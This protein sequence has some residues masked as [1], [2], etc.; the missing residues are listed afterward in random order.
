VTTPAGEDNVIY[1]EGKAAVDT[2]MFAI[3]LQYGADGE[4]SSQQNSLCV[5]VKPDGNNAFA[6]RINTAPGNKDIPTA[7]VG[8][9]MPAQGNW[10]TMPGW[11]EVPVMEEGLHRLVITSAYTDEDAYI[12][13]NAYGGTLGD[14]T[15]YKG[16]ANGSLSGRNGLTTWKGAV[17]QVAGSSNNPKLVDFPN[18]RNARIAL[19]S[20]LEPSP[21][22]IDAYPGAYIR[23][24]D[25]YLTDLMGIL[26]N[27]NG[28]TDQPSTPLTDSQVA[29]FAKV[30]DA[31]TA[32]CND[33]YQKLR[34]IYEYISS[35]FYYD[36]YDHATEGH[37][38]CNP[39]YNLYAL[40]NK[41]KMPNGD[42]VSNGDGTGKVATVCD[43]YA[44]MIIAL[45]RAEG[46][47][48]RI[49]KGF[50]IEG[51]NPHATW[52][53]TTVEGSN[54]LWAEAY[55]DGRWMMLDAKRGTYNRWDR[56][57]GSDPGTWTK[58]DYISYAAFDMSDECFNASYVVTEMRGGDVDGKYLANKGEYEQL[59]AFLNA[60][61]NGKKLNSAYTP[62]DP[63]TWG[64][65][66]DPD[67]GKFL[68]AGTDGYGR[69]F[70]ISW[71]GKGLAGELDLSNFT[72]L[73]YLTINTND[74]T[75]LKVDGCTALAKLYAGYNDLTSFDSTGCP[76][77]EHIALKDN[78]LTQA[79]FLHKGGKVTLKG[80]DGSFG[81]TYDQ[82]AAKPLTIHVNTDTEPGITYDGIYKG[83]TKVSSAAEYSFDPAAGSSYTVRFTNRQDPSIIVSQDGDK[84]G[85]E[86]MRVIF[87]VKTNTDNVTYRWQYRKP[88]TV[89]F[90]D[91]GY[92]SANTA[93]LNIRA[94]MDLNG[95]QYRCIVTRGDGAVAISA[96]VTLTVNEV[97]ET[98]VTSHPI[99]QTAEVG[100]TH[101]SFRF[102]AFGKGLTFQWQWKSPSGSWT[103]S[104]YTGYEMKVAEV[105]SYHDGYQYRC[106]LTDANG[107][108]T[109]TNAATL[110]PK[111]Q[112]AIT[113]NPTNATVTA[114]EKAKFSVAATGEG[115]TYQW[116]YKSPAG[117]SFNQT[118]FAGNK[119][120]TLTVTTKTTHN[121]YQYK[122][123]VTDANG[124][125]KWSSAA[126]LTVQ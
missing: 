14:G 15:P 32:G 97:Y 74:L 21:D 16:W 61:G 49:V 125:E 93:N 80:E 73:K 39:Y 52:G 85:G 12:S 13:G 25:P 89:G 63:G 69:T 71:P 79:A 91:S 102:N 115:L 122:C 123:K 86:S 33:D 56:A 67:T 119:T 45:A 6:V 11:K 34:K 118:T 114:G 7:T 31:V 27:P 26:K 23:Y 110:H 58:R 20:P 75:G 30:A 38:H 77:L 65:A 4:A 126:T 62:T 84:D 105:K 3:R 107:N 17:L 64:S 37:I 36:Y 99:D 19:Q 116:Y 103:D 117:S 124:N 42:Y 46:I 18:V 9:V 76:Q 59:A 96:P 83:S 87:S 43:G 53:N 112:L 44:A 54:H 111:V 55:V 29:Y 81:F 113:S 90:Y 82:D 10:S 78:E 28:A 66:A 24:M 35:S 47:P 72:A 5:F 48:A 40:R 94:E 1:V 100:D 8:T 121:G 120:P 41:G 108:V 88:G 22:T 60:N 101:V 68:E 109:Y 95:Y 104:A 98:F 106:K 92:A 51:Q 57:N 2:K 70:Q 50:G